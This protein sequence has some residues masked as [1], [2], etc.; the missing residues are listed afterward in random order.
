MP[1]PKNQAQDR[2]AGDGDYYLN[3]TAFSHCHASPPS[4]A[5]RD[6]SEGGHV[7][8][9][10]GGSPSCVSGEFLFIDND[11]FFGQVGCDQHSWIYLAWDFSVWWGSGDFRQPRS[12]GCT[13]VAQG[14]QDEL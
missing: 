8:H 5:P 11:C 9:A 1:A 2:K 13:V 6:T 10:E 4:S 3:N 14:R 12:L 7:C